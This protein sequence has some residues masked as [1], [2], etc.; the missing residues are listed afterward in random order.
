MKTAAREVTGPD[1]LPVSEPVRDVF[2]GLALGP[3]GAPVMVPI[4]EM[5]TEPVME[6]VKI[7]Y[8]TPDVYPLLLRRNVSRFG[9]LLGSSDIDVIRPQQDAIK[10]LTGNVLEKLLKGGSYVTLPAGV[11]VEASDEQLKILRLENPAQKAMIDVLNIQ[12]NISFDMA[13]MADQYEKAKSA[14]GITNSFQGKPDNTAQSGRAKEISAIQSAGRLE[15]KRQMKNA[16]Y[17]R[18]FKVM[19]QFMLAY[20]DQPVRFKGLAADGQEVFAEFNRYDFLKRDAAG[21]FYWNDEF[22]FSVDTT[23]GFAQNREALW[24]D[25]TVKLSSGALGNPADT[26]TLLRYWT[27]MERLQYPMAKAMKQ[28]FSEE[29]NRE[30]EAAEAQGGMPNDM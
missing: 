26:R 27:V 14:L 25:A 19:F 17:Q 3:G 30:R 7:P 16:F 5:F 20:A 2:G 11:R 24:E 1:G 22:L 18:L 4:K 9:S 13:A 12:P 23:G 6:K 21:E 29:T 10:K 15:S 28:Q 8:Y